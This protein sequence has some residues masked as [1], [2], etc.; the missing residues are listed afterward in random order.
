[1]RE[2]LIGKL[3]DA[4]LKF[5][6][7]VC[8]PVTK[9][10]HSLVIEH[11][12]QRYKSKFHRHAKKILAFDLTLLAII[13]A[14][15]V[16][17][18]F[19]RSLLPQ[20][21]P[22][23]FPRVEII[24]PQSIVSG[25]PVEYALL[26][27]NPSDQD[28]RCAE[29]HVTLPENFK[30]EAALD[31]TLDASPG[32]TTT[33]AAVAA[34]D[35]DVLPADIIPVSLTTDDGVVSRRAVASFSLGAIPA[36]SVNA[37]R[38]RGTSYGPVGASQMISAD[39][40]YWEEA[41]LA[42]SH[43]SSRVE[44]P[45][46]DTVLPLSLSFASEVLAGQI[47]PITVSYKNTGTAAIQGVSLTVMTPPNFVFTGSNPITSAQLGSQNTKSGRALTFQP[48]TIAPGATGSII[49]W[50]YLSSSAANSA[51]AN[52]K[53]TATLPD[54]RPLAAVRGNAD[55]RATGF[56]LELERP[57]LNGLRPGELLTLPVRFHNS[58]EATLHDLTISFETDDR[59]VDLAAEAGSDLK[60]RVIGD[61]APNSSGSFLLPLRIKENLDAALFAGAQP[62][63]QLVGH[64]KYSLDNGARTVYDDTA[65]LNFAIATELSLKAEA[66]YYGPE[67]DQLGRGAFP[68]APGQETRYR[69]LLTVASSTSDVTSAILEAKLPSGAVWTGKY[70]VSAGEA[71]D[72]LPSSRTVRWTIGAIPAGA[73]PASA[74]LE[75]AI[76]PTAAEVGATLPLLSDIAL[77]GRDT[78][79]DLTVRGAASDI[80]SDPVN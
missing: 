38:L 50:G 62:V 80:F 9:K 57:H 45:I 2:G 23:D 35:C 7:V 13:A 12:E 27:L 34:N 1:M 37:L 66:A 58:G 65:P 24:A 51:A 6:D 42:A 41:A 47:Q 30:F 16:G 22:T 69:L 19:S 4:A 40:S 5:F 43:V 72:Y 68:P 29:L 59:I 17:G 39:L 55:P 14:L 78:F 77:T 79:A 31:A 15:G 74:S 70:S 76:T 28:V 67:G 25:Q 52:F 36:G 60:E 56:S 63:L 8:D 75:V 10:C 26:Y 3:T 71:V 54:G 73:E 49:I 21:L 20:P 11:W 32:A 53:A 44:A 61:V 33:Q 48:D 18:V 64:A 46:T